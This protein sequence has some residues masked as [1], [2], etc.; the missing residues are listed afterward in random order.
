MT[1]IRTSQWRAQTEASLGEIQPV[2][3]RPP[4]AVIRHPANIFL[5][6]A[7]LQHQVF[8]QPSNW[9]V[10]ESRYNRRVHPKGAPQAASNVVFASTLPRTKMTG[11]RDAFIPG[12]ESQHDF[13]KA[14]EIPH[15]AVLRFYIQLRHNLTLRTRGR[16]RRWSGLIGRAIRI[17]NLHRASVRW[18]NSESSRRIHHQPTRRPYHAQP[19]RHQK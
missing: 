8:N 18:R 6:D 1:S 3:D 7:S 17:P 15:A 9:I 13:P 2:A 12:I 11:G 14:N 4:H 19:G 10:R 5:A 16:R